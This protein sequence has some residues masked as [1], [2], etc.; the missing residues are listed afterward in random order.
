M[1]RPSL[2]SSRP[3]TPSSLPPP[4]ANERCDLAT[5][6]HKTDNIRRSL[7]SSVTPKNSTALIIQY[8][9][10]KQDFSATQ[11]KWLAKNQSQNRK[12]HYNQYLVV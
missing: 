6:S 2:Y 4:C 12:E 3:A 10:C 8:T 1:P 7:C 9:G 5:I 11:K